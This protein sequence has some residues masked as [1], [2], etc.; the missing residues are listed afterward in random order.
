[1]KYALTNSVIYTKYEIL[2]DFAVIINGET[3]EAVVP[4]AELETGIKTIDLQGNNLTAG[5]IDLQLNG[6]GGVMFNDQTS[7]ET[8]EIM[9]ETN[10]KSG[11]TSFLPT[12]I[13]APDEN[14]KVR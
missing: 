7:V 11:C 6:C 2:R 9:Q 8:L 4:Q 1:M 10:L 13:T 12:F 3:I 14:I 5:F